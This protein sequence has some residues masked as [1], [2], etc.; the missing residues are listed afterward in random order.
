MVLLFKSYCHRYQRHSIIRG[1][2]IPV[3]TI[4]E[5]V[6]NLQVK[7][8]EENNALILLGNPDEFYRGRFTGS[9]IVQPSE[10]GIILGQFMEL[11]Y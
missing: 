5:N 1:E 7:P 8:N 4:A 6:V 10:N 9:K 11:L 3:D 2:R